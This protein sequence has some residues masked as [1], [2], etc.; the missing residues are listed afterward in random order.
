MPARS[1]EV[2]GER[3][4]AVPSGRV[5]QYVRDEFGVRFRRASDGTER[6]ARYSPLG[7][8]SRE[9]SLLELTD[10]E[11]RRLWRHSQPGWTAPEAGY[12]R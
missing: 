3:W 9:R 11:L 1:F 6:Y 8:R 5:T 7:A 4:E 10:D 12:A 2:D